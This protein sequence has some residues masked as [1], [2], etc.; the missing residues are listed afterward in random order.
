[1]PIKATAL[2]KFLYPLGSNLSPRE[3]RVVFE[4]LQDSG[5]LCQPCPHSLLEGDP[6]AEMPPM[7]YPEHIISKA[8]SLSFSLRQEAIAEAFAFCISYAASE[9]TL[10]VGDGTWRSDKSQVQMSKSSANL[11]LTGFLHATLTWYDCPR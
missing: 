6:H 5:V 8:F 2:Q 11:V 1:M 3:T 4:H 9:I 10:T 7:F